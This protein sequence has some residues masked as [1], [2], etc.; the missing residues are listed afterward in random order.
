MA[1]D[2]LTRIRRYLYFNGMTGVHELAEQMEASLAT[3]RRDLQRL[4][5]QGVIVR[6]HGGA[7]LA[8]A[9]EREVAFEAREHQQLDNKRAIADLVFPHIRRGSAV[10][11]DAGT[12]VLQLAR[13]LRLDPMPLTVF[14]N[15][16][17]VADT[18]SGTD[19]VDVNLLG[20]RVRHFNRCLVG[21]LAEQAIEGLWFDQV[22]LGASAVQPDDTISTPDSGEAS[23]NAVMMRRTDDCLL[24][25]DSS[26]FGRHSTFRVGR[27]DQISRIFTDHELEEDVGRSLR[28]RGHQLFL[29]RKP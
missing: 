16:M 17:T 23:L 21:L 2:R 4:E 19:G 18:L 9:V 26:K 1:G 15:N 13:R 12:T 27:L 5:E 3:V 25:A 22:F 11:L 6:T 20:G 24:L 28:E 7:A 10:F 14:T 8:D 29:T